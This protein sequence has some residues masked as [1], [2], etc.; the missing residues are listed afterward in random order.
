L[1]WNDENPV[2]TRSFNY[3][4][5]RGVGTMPPDFPDFPDFHNYPYCSGF[6]LGSLLKVA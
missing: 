1:S 5:Q 3:F 2:V 6:S 4:S